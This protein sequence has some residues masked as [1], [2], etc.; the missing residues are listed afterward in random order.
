MI[1]KTIEKKRPK[2][3]RMTTKRK[4]TLGDFKGHLR[5]H[6]E[7]KDGFSRDLLEMATKLSAEKKAERIKELDEDVASF[8]EAH[9][10]IITVTSHHQSYLLKHWHMEERDWENEWDIP[11]E[12]FERGIKTA[13]AFL[14]YNK[15]LSRRYISYFDEII[16]L[17]EEMLT[18]RQ[19]GEAELEELK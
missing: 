14:E 9:D 8:K 1:Q 19:N 7:Q 3:F 13:I 10:V 15:T 6:A 16:Q 17:L 11:L 5:S 12:V 2:L 4:V 18:F